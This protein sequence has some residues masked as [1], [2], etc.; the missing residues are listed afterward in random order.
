MFLYISQFIGVFCFS[1]LVA[2]YY[3]RDIARKDL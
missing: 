1:V 3:D 2:K